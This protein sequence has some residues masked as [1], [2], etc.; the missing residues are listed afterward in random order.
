MT[1]KAKQLIS[2]YRYPLLALALGLVIM[3][4]PVGDGTETASSK[5]EGEQRLEN[6]LERCEGVGNAA[7]LLSENGAVIVCDGAD[8][9]AVRLCVT[10]AVEAYTGFSSDRIQVIKT[11]PNMGG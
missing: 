3:L 6:V 1:E 10:K 2:K 5:Q 4:I 7:A 11:A 8:N 9:A